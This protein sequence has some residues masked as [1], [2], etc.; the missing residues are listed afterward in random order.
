[1]RSTSALP[2]LTIKTVLVW[3]DTYYERSGRWPTTRSGNIEGSFGET[4]KGID[5]ALNQGRR[6]FRT[7]M[8]LAKLLAARRHVHNR[9][10][11]PA[12]T[13]KQILAWADAHHKRMGAWPTTTSGPVYE[14]PAQ[15]WVAVSMALAHGYRGLA[16]GTSLPMLLAE[17]RGVR[18]PGAPPRLSIKQILA[19]ADA[20]HE[21][22]GQW[23]TVKA[24]TIEGSSGETWA[25]INRSLCDG[26]RG[27]PA[28]G[29]LARL[30]AKYRRARN[31]M[32][33]PSLS[34]GQILKWADAEHR[35]TDRWPTSY[36][37]RVTVAPR[38]TWLGISSALYSGGRG[39]PGG[40]TLRQLLIQHG[41][42][43]PDRRSGRRS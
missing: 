19:W 24:G 36:S 2:R 37:G 6:G 13:I 5:R 30:L 16:G 18:H 12:L 4:W 39:L 40:T 32:A 28:G 29:S 41:R 10:A 11:V 21:Q 14:E 9:V 31:H 17:R 15:S 33:L 26:R 43:K 25:R 34:I 38:E 22:T 1:M 23:P 42:I 20:Y 8:S 27:L 7:K 35:Q 3:A